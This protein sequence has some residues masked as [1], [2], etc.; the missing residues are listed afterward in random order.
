MRSVVLL[1]H[2]I[3]G[4]ESDPDLKGWSWV[5]LGV[6]LEI[7]GWSWVGLGVSCFGKS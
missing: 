2:E 1:L 5:G 7:R 4:A 6:G 3:Q